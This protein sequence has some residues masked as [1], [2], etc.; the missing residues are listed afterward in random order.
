MKLAIFVQARI[1]SKRFPKKIFS[2]INGKKIIEILIEKLQKI[3]HVD[4]IIFLIPNTKK[5]KDLS[6]LL[7]KLDIEVFKGSENNVL[8]RYYLAAKKYNVKNIIRITS[9][10]PL[11]DIRLSQKV[12]RKFLSGNYNYVSNINP[13]TFPDGMD[14]EIFKFRSLERAWKS[15]KTK[16]EKEHVTGYIRKN[17]KKKFNIKS[18]YDLSK[19]RITLDYKEDLILLRKIFNYFKPDIH[20][21][22]NKIIN[23]KNK[24]PNWFNINKKYV[25][26]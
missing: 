5:N 6:R 24:K 15:S 1:T 21:G 2:E 17:E 13:P 25:L 16:T 7:E 11:L 8:E 12:I 14:I 9:D 20:F 3:K 23:L 22:L 19:I 26:K 4:K 10:C 18:D